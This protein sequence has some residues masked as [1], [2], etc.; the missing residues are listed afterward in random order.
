[1][2]CVLFVFIVVIFVVAVIVVVV[3]VVVVFALVVVIIILIIRQV[4]FFQNWGYGTTRVKYPKNTHKKHPNTQTQK[5]AP[6]FQNKGFLNNAILWIIR[7]EYC[8]SIIL[9]YH[10]TAIWLAIY[11]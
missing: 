9:A 1:M 3:F 7:Y 5:I 4:V 2:V 8:V 10:Q 11:D 6:T